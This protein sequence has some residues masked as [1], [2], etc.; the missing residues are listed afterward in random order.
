MSRSIA[1]FLARSVET[2]LLPMSERQRRRTLVRLAGE[3]G[4]RSEFEVQ[5]ARGPLSFT[6]HSGY[7]ASALTR[8]FDDEPETLKFMDEIAPGEVLWDIGANIGMF[9][10]YAALGR[11]VDVVAFEPSGFNFG[12]LVEA[13]A[14]NGLDERIKPFC[15]A[16]S[17]TTGIEDLLMQDTEVGHAS[18]S[19]GASENQFGEF[20]RAFAQSVLTFR[21]D[22]LVQTFGLPAPDHIKL[23]V[24]GVEPQIL[25]GAPGVLRHAKRVI[26]EV[27]GRNA[28]EA[29]AL[30]DGPLNAA[31]LTEDLAFR[32]QGHRRN[33][34]FLRN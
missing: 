1:R 33:R 17:D 21:A 7:S 23:D 22:D 12:A 10:V 25:A 3:L 18:N 6:A 15:L 34:L 14:R 30:I 20:K 24:D 9:S 2:L 5:T 16:L 31:G 8:F 32:D 27:E 29:A 19:I 26:I 13:I 4:K 28:D 11:A